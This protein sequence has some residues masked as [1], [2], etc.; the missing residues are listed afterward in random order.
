MLV[1]TTF[2]D[3]NGNVCNVEVKRNLQDWEITEYMNMLQLLAT[4]KLNNN[5]DKLLWTSNKKSTFTVNSFYNYLQGQSNLDGMEFP[6][7]MIWN[8]SAPP[9]ISFFGWEA[10]K[11]RILTIDNLMRRGIILTN[12]CF[13]CQ[14]DAEST[15]HL[16]LWC[17]FT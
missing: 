2:D 14:K 8:T 5:D 11:E 15:N 1:R 16:L 9:R 4:F 3:E 13:L 6:S 17:P 12:R 7:R 10:A